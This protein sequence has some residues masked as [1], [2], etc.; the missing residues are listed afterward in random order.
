MDKQNGQK[1]MADDRRW[2]QQRGKGALQHTMYFNRSL[3][4]D[5]GVTITDLH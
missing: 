4:N 5:D 2:I 1:A 3:L